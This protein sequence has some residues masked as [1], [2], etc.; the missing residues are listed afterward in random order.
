MSSEEF[1][2]NQI[3]KIKEELAKTPDNASLL[4]DL[5]V[6]Y[7]LIGEYEKAVKILLSAVQIEKENSTYLFNLANA[8]SELEK[9]SLAKQY[10][11]DALENNPDHIPSLTNL[12][13]AYEATGD[14]DKARELFEY[15]TKLAPGNA[16]AFFNFGNFLLRQNRHIEAVKNYEKAIEIEESFVDAYFN[17]AWILKEVKAY[18]KALSFAEKGLKFEPD[19][20]DLEKI[21]LEIRNNL[22]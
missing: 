4:H 22:G 6:G 8:Y 17:I 5:G 2:K 9:Y 15:I 16:L 13:D 1:I 14:V 20:K 3:D 10:Y 12:A 21:I 18:K 19:H 7:Y 11:L